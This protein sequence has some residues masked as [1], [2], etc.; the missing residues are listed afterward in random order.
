MKRLKLLKRIMINRCAIIPGT[1]V[2][3][4]KINS[5]WYKVFCHIGWLKVPADY[6]ELKE[7]E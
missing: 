1:V 7:Q 2:D 5:E 6:F 4:I 3:V